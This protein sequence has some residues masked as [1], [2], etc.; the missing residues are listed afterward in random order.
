MTSVSVI[1]KAYNEEAHIAAAIESALAGLNGLQGEV[2]L[3]DSASVDN[4][5]KIASKYPIS[6]L[7]IRD[8]NER[9]CGAGAQAGYLYAKG[10]FLYLMD[11]DMV[12]DATFLRKALDYLTAHSDVAGV[13]GRIS[14]MSTKNLEFQNR[15]Q[16]LAQLSPLGDVDRLAGGGLYRRKAIDELGYLTDRNLHGYEEFDLGVRLRLRGWKLVRL[17]ANA[18]EHYGHSMSTYRLLWHRVRMGYVFAT[19]EL[20]RASFDGNYLVHVARTLREFR[21]WIAVLTCW[22]VFGGMLLYFSSKLVVLGALAVLGFIITILTMRKRSLSNG[23]YM[24]L[25]WQVFAL[26]M[27]FG[28][29]RR[30]VPP[31]QPLRIEVLKFT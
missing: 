23:I 18:A 29:L 2:L 31:R 4:T 14:E 16:K 20:L 28:L 10:E 13:G 24:L 9:R 1:I 7:E 5:V 6:I 25:G 3:V 11:G 15:A 27:L 8:V 30:R 26:G 19:G 21:L 17:D 12:L 22:L